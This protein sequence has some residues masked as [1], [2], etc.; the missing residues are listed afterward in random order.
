MKALMHFLKGNGNDSYAALIVFGGWVE[1]L[2][3]ASKILESDPENIEIL[4][5]IAEQKYSLN[6]LISL[7]SNFQESIKV[8]ECI[9]RLKKLKSSFE[10]FEIYYEK[11][12]LQLDTVN[13]LISASDYESSMSPKIA[14]EINTLVTEIRQELI[15]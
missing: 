9:L 7:L 2:Y 10:K 8:S 3:I 6:S 4:D 15:N 14:L 1:A 13:K 12:N 5:R 11:E